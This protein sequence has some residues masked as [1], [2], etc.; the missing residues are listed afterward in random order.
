MMAKLNFQQPLLKSSVTHDDHL[1][2]NSNMLI[3]HAI[4]INYYDYMKI[5]IY[6][7]SVLERVCVSSTTLHME[8]NDP[9]QGMSSVGRDGS[10]SRLIC[11]DDGSL[12]EGL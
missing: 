7:R 11:Q 9:L 3:W 6:C 1:G 8:T 4:I 10:E 2:N 12:E 5:F